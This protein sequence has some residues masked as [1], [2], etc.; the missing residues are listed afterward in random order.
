[1]DMQPALQ[2]GLNGEPLDMVAL[3]GA[4]ARET[5]LQAVARETTLQSVVE[6]LQ[7]LPRP[8]TKIHR[9]TISLS[10][11]LAD[12]PVYLGTLAKVQAVAV[13][14]L[15]G[16]V[17]P[18]LKFGGSAETPIPLAK[19]ETREN[20]DVSGLLITSAAGGGSLTLEIHGR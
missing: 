10:A 4:V 8:S 17:V 1:M 12:V 14:D 13:V 6:A 9:V 20:L 19:G 7:A 5:T 2:M 16:T 18:S 11:L 15:T 3:L